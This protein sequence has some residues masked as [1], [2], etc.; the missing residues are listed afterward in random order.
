MDAFEARRVN[1]TDYIADRYES[2]RAA[3]CRA[4]GKNPNLINLVLTDNADYRRNIGEKLARDIERKAAA[5][6]TSSST[7]WIQLEETAGLMPLPA[8]LKE[9]RWEAL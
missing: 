4:T 3:F 2:N 6:H 5:T 7:A 1:L 8:R 9:G